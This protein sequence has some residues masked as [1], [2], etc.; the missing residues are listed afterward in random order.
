MQRLRDRSWTAR[1][2][3][4]G[5]PVKPMATMPVVACT[6]AFQEWR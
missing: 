6:R 4:R 3:G 1:R 2:P 5:Q